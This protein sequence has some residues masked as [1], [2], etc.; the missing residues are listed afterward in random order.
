[1]LFVG[2]ILKVSE[3]IELMKCKNKAVCLVRICNIGIRVN[4]FSRYVFF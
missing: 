2:Y 3:F 1:M 4:G